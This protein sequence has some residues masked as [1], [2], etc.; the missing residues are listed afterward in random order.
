MNAPDGV[1]LMWNSAMPV[2]SLVLAPV[3][4]AFGPVVA[5]NIAVVLAVAT[6][7]WA[8]YLALRRLA[9]GVLGPLVG[10]LVYAF[11]PYVVGHATLHLNLIVVWIPPVML[12][13]LHDLLVGRRSSPG[14]LGAAIGLLAGIQVLVFEEVLATGAVAA[15]V[16]AVV[17]VAVARDG[18]GLRLGARR[19]ARAAAPAAVV[20]ALVVAWPLAVQFLG[21]QRID[22]PVQDVGRFSMDLLNV[23]LPTPNQLLAPD[24]V[25]EVSSRFSG[26]YHEATGYVGVPLLLVLAAAVALGRRDRRVVVAGGM[27][28]AMGVLSLGP[29]L[30]VNG[31]DTGI[32]L[33]WLPFVHLPLIEHALPGRLTLYMWLAIAALVALAV[34]RLHVIGGRHGAAGL[35]AVAAALVF[36]LPAPP[37]ASDEEIPAFFR[38]WDETAVQDDAIVLVAPHFTNGAGAAPMLWSAV[39][40]NRPRLYEAYAYVPRP[41]GSPSY[42]PPATQL[43]RIMET[44]QDEGANLVAGGGVRAQA[45]LDLEEQGISHV[46]VGPMRHRA[47]MVA[48]FTDLLGRPPRKL[49]GVELW[50]LSP[51]D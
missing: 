19:V 33:P 38:S 1:N 32:P 26:L 48:F 5:Y 12:L 22:A 41:D 27:A 13:L 40:G 20:F 21:P 3:T 11:S 6:A 29:S 31:S 8:C 2:V 25:T 37:G 51:G 43:T 15:A 4:L 10:G 14:R 16:L 47:Q 30:V 50:D 36:V 9:G 34:A 18:E 46:I 28:I 49:E 17:M 42:G 23:V 35:A 39:A 7:G 24:A 45:L 44:I